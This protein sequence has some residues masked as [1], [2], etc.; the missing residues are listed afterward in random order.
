MRIR[1]LE[2]GR[3]DMLRDIGREIRGSIRYEIIIIR[4][5]RYLMGYRIGDGTYGIWE[6]KII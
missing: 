6:H 5:M 2:N 4:I 1:R 3:R